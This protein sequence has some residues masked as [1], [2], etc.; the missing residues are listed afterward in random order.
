[1]DVESE[2]TD[3]SRIGSMPCVCCQSVAS[4]RGDDLANPRM[5]PRWSRIS[6]ET[7]SS[8]VSADDGV[9]LLMASSLGKWSDAALLDRCGLHT[10]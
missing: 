10:A 2:M 9:S 8:P 6:L 1:M 7:V 5:R 3:Y 4:R